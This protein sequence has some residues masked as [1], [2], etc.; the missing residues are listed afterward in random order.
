MT[1][2]FEMPGFPV[3]YANA[4]GLKYRQFNIYP[5][6]V[7]GSD[8]SPSPNPYGLSSS[9][10]T[11]NISDVD[12]SINRSITGS[13]TTFVYR[14]YFK[15]D[16]TSD[17]WQFRTRSNDGSWLWIDHDATGSTTALDTTKAIVK[18][19]GQHT[20]VTVTSANLTLSASDGDGDDLYYAIAIVGGN[21]PG[22]GSLKVD[23]RRDGGSWQNDGTGFYYYDSRKADG[24]DP[25]S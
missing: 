13:K 8:T 22:G 24:F 2:K 6:S 1:Y 17:S 25:N 4:L 7:P 11:P 10:W 3:Y 5:I 21:D 15:P 16:Q 12:T 18:N 9:A 20:A 23:F 14:G 19:G